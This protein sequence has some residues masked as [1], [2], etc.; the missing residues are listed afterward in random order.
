MSMTKKG[1]A[2]TFEPAH[3]PS[4]WNQRSITFIPEIFGLRKFP[5]AQTVYCSLRCSCFHPNESLNFPQIDVLGAL[6]L[7]EL[8]EAYSTG[9]GKICGHMWGCSTPF[10]PRVLCPTPRL[11]GSKDRLIVYTN[12]ATSCSF[13]R[14]SQGL[15]IGNQ[16]GLLIE[17]HVVNQTHR[18]TLP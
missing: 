14:I 6:N 12:D 9:L 18:P 4:R 2:K 3:K 8:S 15:V 13:L 10:S 17:V 11:L 16:K 1:K 5:C 7:D